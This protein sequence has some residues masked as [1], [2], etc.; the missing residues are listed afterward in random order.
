MFHRIKSVATHPDFSMDVVFADGAAKRYDMTP[1]LESHK[2]F[3]VLRDDPALFAEAAVDV[4]GYGVVWNDDLDIS[5]DELFEN[6][7]CIP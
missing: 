1:L 7:V 6:G 5:C 4:G 2:D 3:C